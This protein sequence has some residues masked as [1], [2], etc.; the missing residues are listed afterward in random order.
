MPLNYLSPTR[1]EILIELRR[2]GSATVD[3]LAAS[4]NFTVGAVRQQLLTLGA[5][6]LVMHHPVP[7]GPGRPRHVYELT[8]A[9][10][11]LFRPD[12]GETLRRLA[13]YLEEE[14]PDV[15]DAFIRREMVREVRRFERRV[16]E[17][18]PGDEARLGR[19]AECLE[20][21]GFLP[22]V[23]RS[24]DGGFTLTLSNC[25]VI[26]FAEGS[27]RLCDLSSK[28]LLE[29]VPGYDVR[30][31]V[32]RKEGTPRCVYRLAPRTASRATA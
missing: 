6:G 8:A 17:G 31:E 3:D 28:A 29:I 23:A 4:L 19:L 5:D 14:S 1:Q 12:Q 27:P 32:W 15:L 11:P 9:A 10:N 30:R 22:S 16:L 20:E 13:L 7:K 18:P 25:P 21:K 24:P 26:E 2:R